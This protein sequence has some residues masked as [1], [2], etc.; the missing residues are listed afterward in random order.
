MTGPWITSGGY[1]A[2][3][4]VLQQ[5]Q[6]FSSRRVRP[7][8]GYPS[9]CQE[10]AR[11]PRNINDP[12]F[13]YTSLGL[14]PWASQKEIKRA[15]RLLLKRYHPDGER[16]NRLMFDRIEEIYRILT[17]PIAQKIYHSTP[18]GC[19]YIDSWEER[20]I[21][22][23]L[24][25][26]GKTIKDAVEAGAV[27]GEA[28][29][30][31]GSRANDDE[32]EPEPEDE[33]PALESR[34]RSNWDFLA[35]LPLDGNEATQANEWYPLLLDAA[36]TEGYLGPIKVLLTQTQRGFARKASMIRIPRDLEVTEENAAKL[37]GSVV[38]S[39]HNVVRSI[40]RQNIETR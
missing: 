35:Q 37:V 20:K 33:E 4:I 15:C 38:D 25:A 32:P 23:K 21:K 40:G 17:D 31:P 39:Q 29:R 24:E 12:N 18:P 8:W 16:P 6:V 34:P 3:P 19:I 14:V 36:R 30:N 10:L 28:N 22:A 27:H 2:R 9:S 13:Y 7:G 5:D 1:T 11:L 26:E